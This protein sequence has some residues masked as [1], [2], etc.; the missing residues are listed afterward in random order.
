MSGLM[1]CP[2]CK[3]NID[4]DSRY[5]DQCGAQILVCSLCGRPGT[6][7]RCKFDGKEMIPAGTTPQQTDHIVQPQQPAPSAAAAPSAASAPPAAGEKIKLSSQNR[8]INIEASNGDILGR[9]KGPFA[10]I[11]GEFSH[12]SGAHCNLLKTAAGWS[13]VDLGSTNG[14]FYNNRRLAPN[15]PE[16]LQ[17]GTILKL[18]D[19]ELQ[20]TYGAAGGTVRI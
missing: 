1:Q 6:G 2:S 14:T 7:K 8:G 4:D 18:A 19:I 9:T 15:V 3:E 16:P 20:I 12:I 10:G 11:F 13:I 17:S 5:C